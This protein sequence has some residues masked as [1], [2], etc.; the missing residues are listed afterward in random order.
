MLQ[1]LLEDDGYEVF[2]A[3]DGT[4]AIERAETLHPDLVLLDIAMPDMD[5]IELLLKLKAHGDTRGISVIVV[6][7]YDRDD[8]V[9]G[10]LELGATD[11][12]AKPVSAAVV[13]AR[14]RNVIRI[15]CRHKKVVAAR[16]LQA[17]SASVTSWCHRS[18]GVCAVAAAYG[19]LLGPDAEN[20]GDE[21]HD[22]L[23]PGPWR[24][25]DLGKGR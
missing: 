23:R 16:T 14:V 17:A 25:S 7:A 20:V 1:D 24:D 22:H 4:E 18:L 11:F 9:V 2:V 3:A 13:R 21:K 15:R 5:G 10:A 8:K 12:I 6:T 19:P